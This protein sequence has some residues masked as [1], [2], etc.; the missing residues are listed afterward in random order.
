MC[1]TT[2]GARPSCMGRVCP[3]P[4]SEGP[5]WHK[6]QGGHAA[7]TIRLSSSTPRVNL[8]PGIKAGVLD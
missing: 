8:T 5:V 1:A 4:R 7:R 6:P 2:P 3:R